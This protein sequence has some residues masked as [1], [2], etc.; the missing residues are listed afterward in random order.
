MQDDSEDIEI[1]LVINIIS[2]R[3]LKEGG[4]AILAERIKNHHIDKVGVSINMPFVKNL[5]R[6]WVSEYDILANENKA[7]EH[8][9]WAIIINRAP[10]IP[11]EE[12]VIIP[13]TIIPMCPTEE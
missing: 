3:R 10:L 9:P 7:D 6:V 8:R 13:A 2:L 1:T 12:C 5:L 11:H 4:A